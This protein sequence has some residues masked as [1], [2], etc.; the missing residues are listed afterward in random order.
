[1][2]GIIEKD[3]EYTLL[4]NYFDLLSKTG[5]VS[6]SVVYR[7]LAWLFIIDFSEMMYPKLRERHYA[8]IHKAL[9]NIFSKGNCLLS[10]GYT[11]RYE[12]GLTTNSIE[13]W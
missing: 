12:D 3:R 5:Y 11:V 13:A 10:Y 9:V 8:K 1:M 2:L 4:K 7:Y 6:R